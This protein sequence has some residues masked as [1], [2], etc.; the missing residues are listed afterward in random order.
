MLQHD[1]VGNRDPTIGEA[2]A[3]DGADAAAAPEVPDDA[4]EK[5]AAAQEHINS[6]NLDAER[7]ATKKAM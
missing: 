2:A 6:L 5:I 1:R 7:A 3:S 4:S